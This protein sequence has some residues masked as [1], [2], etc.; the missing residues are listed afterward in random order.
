M[1]I[2]K[3]F[4]GA[5][6]Q[7]IRDH[8]KLVT[9]PRLRTWQSID[10]DLNWTPTSDRS[11]P[12]LDIRATPPVVGDDGVTL[13]SNVS[14]LIGTNANDDP[15]HSDMSAFYEGVSTVLDDLYS[16]FRSGTAGT[17]RDT[18]DAYITN[19]QPDTSALI[20]VGGFEHGEPLSPYEDGGAYFIGLNFIIHFSRTDY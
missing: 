3:L 15:T 10:S 12:M 13:M 11:F 7:T 4:E 18:F 16:Q 14:I 9:M 2:P 8:A 19:T 6:A 20:D 5:I 1:N 17:E